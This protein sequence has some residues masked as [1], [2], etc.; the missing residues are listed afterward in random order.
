MLLR[1]FAIISCRARPQLLM[2]V[3]A[4]IPVIWRRAERCC[5]CS[6]SWAVLYEK[7]GIQSHHTHPQQVL[8][9]ACP[10][11]M[12]MLAAV[13]LAR[14]LLLGFLRCCVASTACSAGVGRLR[15]CGSWWQQVSLFKSGLSMAQL[16][17]VFPCCLLSCVYFIRMNP[18]T[19]AADSSSSSSSSREEADD[20]RVAAVSTCAVCGVC[21]SA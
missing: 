15:A 11:V 14:A 21:D 18:C 3:V 8:A 16:R 6:A 19:A 5:Y 12:Y 10:N 2:G 4:C 17:F 20:L 9:A 1:S 7:C 13:F